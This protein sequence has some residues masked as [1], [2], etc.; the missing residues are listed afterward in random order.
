MLSQNQSSE[1]DVQFNNGGSWS[2]FECEYYPDKFL[3]VAQPTIC[4]EDDDGWVAINSGLSSAAAIFS[5][6][7]SVGVLSLFDVIISIPS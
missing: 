6:S 5:L 1:K 2:V 4:G 3:F 7:I